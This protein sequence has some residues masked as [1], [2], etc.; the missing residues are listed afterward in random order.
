MTRPHATD[1]PHGC[2]RNALSGSNEYDDDRETHSPTPMLPRDGA[3]RADGVRTCR[4]TQ[5]CI[6]ASRSGPQMSCQPSSESCGVSYIQLARASF[7]LSQSTSQQHQQVCCPIERAEWALHTKPFILPLVL[8]TRTCC[9]SYPEHARTHVCLCRARHSVFIAYA[10]LTTGHAVYLTLA[11][12][13]ICSACSSGTSVVGRLRW[14]P[15]SM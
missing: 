14:R 13:Y 11:S 9:C 1:C 2:P 8:S 12:T 5:T 10:S 15:R 4:S 3:Q 6:Q 7:D